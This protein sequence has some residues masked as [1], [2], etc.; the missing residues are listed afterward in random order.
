[1]PRNSEAPVI[2]G[3]TALGLTA[4]DEMEGVTEVRQGAS[5]F[6]GVV[7]DFTAPETPL[8][9]E[10]TEAMVQIKGATLR[11]TNNGDPKFSVR[12]EVMDGEYEG[13]VF[14]D[15]LTF[16]PPKPGGS[17]GTMWRVRKLCAAIKYDLPASL[18]GSEILPWIKQFREELL[19][20]QFKCVIGI[21]RSTKINPKSDPPKVYDPRQ[22]IDT[23][24]A[25][26]DRS[27]DD[28]F[29]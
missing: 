3:A 22:T 27:L 13:W 19:G 18:S 12:Y 25:A 15:D 2:N 28:L 24:I 4:V 6:D 8:I 26:G 11:E 1:M 5:K 9:P 17:N 29:G 23:F 7:Y 21:N 14:F 10:G 20:E 16:I